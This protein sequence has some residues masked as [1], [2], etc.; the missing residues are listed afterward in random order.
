MAL[1]PARLIHIANLVIFIFLALLASINKLD[2][3]SK[4]NIFAQ[5]IQMFTNIYIGFLAQWFNKER[6]LDFEILILTRACK[7]KGREQKGLS[8]TPKSLFPPVFTLY[9][10][11]ADEEAIFTMVRCDK[12]VSSCFLFPLYPG[13]H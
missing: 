11:M 3:N 6:T 10:N 12:P 5:K 4:K 1:N 13:L 2:K 8:P 7:R 9:L